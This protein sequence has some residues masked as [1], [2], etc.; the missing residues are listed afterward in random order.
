MTTY[1]TIG[2]FH[3]G[4]RLMRINGTTLDLPDTPANAR[5]FSRPTS[6]RAVGAFP[7][8][9]LLA[10]CELSTHAIC[11]LAIKPLCHGEPSMSAHCWTNSGRRACL[12]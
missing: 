10:L 11:A 12:S 1:Q 3:C 7:Q 9:R 8:I 6:K 5:T 4:W 2:A